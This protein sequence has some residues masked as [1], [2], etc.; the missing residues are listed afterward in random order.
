MSRRCASQRRDITNSN[1]VPS[2]TRLRPK[3]IAQRA[4]DR[5]ACH[6]APAEAADGPAEPQI[7]AVAGETEVL[8]DEWHDAR[9]HCRVETQQEPI[10]TVS[11]TNAMFMRACIPM[12]LE[13]ST[14]AFVRYRNL[15]N[16]AGP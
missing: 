11:A 5:I 10:A 4:R 7:A 13:R 14:R 6:R 8:A 1:A 16:L 15:S 3:S 12:F 9:N 2:N